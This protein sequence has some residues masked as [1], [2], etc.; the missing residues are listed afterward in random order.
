LKKGPFVATNCGSIPENLVESELF[1]H[2]RGSFT[3]AIESH[4]GLFE[5]ANRGT[6]FLDEIGEM[7]LPVQAKLLR[8]LQDGEVRRVGG[9]ADRKVQVRVVAATHRNLKEEVKAGRF[10]EDLFYRLSVAEVTI[11]PLRE[12]QE[13][14][15]LLADHFLE[16]FAEQNQ[17]AKKSLD[18][19]VLSAMALY[20]WPGNV[21]ELE[22]LV[23]N[24][25]IFS[26]G[27]RIG[28]ED[29]R[30]RPDLA[31]LLDL[32]PLPAIEKKVAAGAADPLRAAIDRGEINLSEAKRRFEREEIV[33]ALAMHRGKVGE[34][35]RHLGIPRPQLSR[36]L[37]YHHLQK[38]PV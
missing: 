13:D 10:R 27:P 5:Q 24:L 1:G 19:K 23:Y 34:A 22:N 18:P 29:L 4:A 14:I 38:E 20:G 6:L 26:D 12:R 11:P 32:P 9:C 7:P 28:P 36:L 3:G 16:K 21:R 31:A 33:R 37:S 2:E 8:V 17:S 15:P 35:A 30:Q 25:C